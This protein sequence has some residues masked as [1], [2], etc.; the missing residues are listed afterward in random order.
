MVIGM[1]G[2][3]ISL[4]SKIGNYALPSFSAFLTASFAIGN[5]AWPD[6]RNRYFIISFAIYTMCSAFIS[7]WH[8][9]CWKRKQV[10][11]EANNCKKEDLPWYAVTFFMITHAVTIGILG[12]AVYKFAWL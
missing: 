1:S 12:V 5:I 2:D 11:L 7:Y 9:L 10:R 8:R 3:P 4:V 6:G